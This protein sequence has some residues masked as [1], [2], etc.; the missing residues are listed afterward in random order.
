LALVI[1]L[2]VGYALASHVEIVAAWR[3]RHGFRSLASAAVPSRA[4]AIAATAVAIAV[5]GVAYAHVVAPG[6]QRDADHWAAAKVIGP[7]Q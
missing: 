2:A 4:A 1:L 5:A 6:I 7:P 3:R